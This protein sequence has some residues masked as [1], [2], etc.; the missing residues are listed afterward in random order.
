[1]GIGWLVL[2]ILLLITV[3]WFGF[4]VAVG[5]A[6]CAVLSGRLLGPTNWPHCG[7]ELR[8][9]ASPPRRTI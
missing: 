9:S 7:A 6:V 8:S 3:V 4:L 2:V 5:M 1:M